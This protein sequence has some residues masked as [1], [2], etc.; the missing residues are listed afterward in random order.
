MVVGT[1]DELVR[2]ALEQAGPDGDVIVIDR[3]A[4]R[5]ERLWQEV[6]D[7]RLWCTIGDADVIPLPDG[8]ADLVLGAPASDEVERVRR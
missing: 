2:Q 1:Q 4:E 8:S 7:P 5:L 3:S 6:G